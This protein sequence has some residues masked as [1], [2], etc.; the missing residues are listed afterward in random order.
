MKFKNSNNIVRRKIVSEHKDR[1]KIEGVFID[2]KKSDCDLQ[3]IEIL[4]FAN[5]FPIFKKDSLPLK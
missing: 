1:Q 3:K 5:K 4:T 2:K